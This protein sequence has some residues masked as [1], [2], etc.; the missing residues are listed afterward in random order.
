MAV[1]FI[2]VDNLV[3]AYPGIV[4]DTVADARIRD[5]FPIRLSNKDMQP[6]NGRWK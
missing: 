3:A 2:P 5:K 6:G 4:I 1:E